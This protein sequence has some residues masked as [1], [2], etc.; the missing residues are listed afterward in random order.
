MPPVVEPQQAP[1][2]K[3]RGVSDPVSQSG[4]RP[5][6][7]SRV[8]HAPPPVPCQCRCFPL[9]RVAR[10]SRDRRKRMALILSTKAGDNRSVL[11][12]G[13]AGRSARACG[14]APAHDFAGALGRVKAALASLAANAALTRPTCS[15]WLAF[16][17]ATR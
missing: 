5:A 11:R 1:R 7:A 9:G 17:G 6:V 12:R 14:V 10:L 3:E 13:S 8:A 4:L 2:T 15:R 16:T